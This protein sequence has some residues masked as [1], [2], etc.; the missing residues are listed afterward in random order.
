MHSCFSSYV[1]FP[2]LR[3]P[4]DV[5]V[6]AAVIPSG[7]SRAMTLTYQGDPIP[8]A[9][10]LGYVALANYVANSEYFT[11]TDGDDTT[12]AFWFDVTGADSEPAGSVAAD[13]SYRV[14]ISGALDLDDIGNAIETAINLADIGISVINPDDGTLTLVQDVPGAVGN[15]WLVS[16]N[17]TDEGFVISGYS[18][19]DPNFDSG[20]DPGQELDHLGIYFAGISQ[21]AT[22]KNYVF[23][24]HSSGEL[25][26][27]LSNPAVVEFQTFRCNISITQPVG[28]SIPTG[29]YLDFTVEATATDALPV[30]SIR[31]D[32]NDPVRAS[33]RVEFG[34]IN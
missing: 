19:S 29:Q 9:A 23:R 5:V 15:T 33:I 27:G 16:D 20:M 11:I 22:P 25:T 10:F 24:I 17:V 8:A 7:F 32:S 1:T 2:Q 21:L 3:G 26:L 18:T 14:N 4:A 34:G 28:F 30:W 6:P 13:N 12:H 31:V